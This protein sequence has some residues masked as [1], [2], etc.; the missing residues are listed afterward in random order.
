MA[1]GDWDA[2]E[3]GSEATWLV[4][5]YFYLNTI[6]N[7]VIMLNLLISIISESFENVTGNKDAFTYYVKA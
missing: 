1:L 3:F 5:I 6:F 7:T 2:G 4:W